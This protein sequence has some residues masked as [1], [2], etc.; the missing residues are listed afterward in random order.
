[1]VKEILLPDL[2][3]GIDGADVSEVVV[4]VGDTVSKDD[5]LLVLES[6]KASME[7]PAE[8]AGVIKEIL[9]SPGDSLE[10]GALLMRVE[11]SKNETSKNTNQQKTLKEE[12]KEVLLP[13][14]GEGIDGADV[15]EVVV[16]VGDTVSKDDTLLVLESD[17]ASMEIPAE[18]AG[19]IK[20]I[21]VSAG[22]SL[23]TGA[24]LMRVEVKTSSSEPS[25]ENRTECCYTRGSSRKL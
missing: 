2:G 17:K 25:L 1:M 10:T 9:V 14:L 3:E 19:V 12:L 20:E 6:D 21:L 13:D 18:D 16:S 15:S 22:D 5:T 24:L 8:D 7:I 23:E 11:V 4:S